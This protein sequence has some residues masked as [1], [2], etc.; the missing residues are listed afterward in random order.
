MQIEKSLKDL[1]KKVDDRYTTLDNNIDNL[2]Q[3]FVD[4]TDELQKSLNQTSVTL[5]DI[6]VRL[7]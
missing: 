6:Q 2:G 4:F 5:K 1:E 3:K 7:A